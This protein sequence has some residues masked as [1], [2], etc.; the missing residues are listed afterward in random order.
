MLFFA[1]AKNPVEIEE[2]SA[3]KVETGP[4]Q[5]RYLLKLETDA[6]KSKEPADLP[7]TVVHSYPSA[8]FLTSFSP[9]EIVAR[10]CIQELSERSVVPVNYRRSYILTFEKYVFPLIGNM[11][12]NSVLESD[13][14]AVISYENI[15]A[16]IGFQRYRIFLMIASIFRYSMAHNLIL[17]NPCSNI[18]CFYQQP[19][20]PYRE[21][22]QSECNALL[23]AFQAARFK[24][25]IL[26]SF[27]TGIPIPEALMLSR[28]NVDL[29]SGKAVISQRM[30]VNGPHD[31]FPR[32]I[33][34][35]TIPLPEDGISILRDIHLPADEIYFFNSEKDSA[36]TT[37]M[38]MDLQEIRHHSGISDFSYRDL[39]ENFIMR[40]LKADVDIASLENY[41]GYRVGS[42]ITRIYVNTAG[43]L[44][45]SI[46]ASYRKKRR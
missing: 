43:I 14:K 21:F 17:F 2:T 4:K 31:S 29:Y 15:P 19:C 36:N 16:C 13:V 20:K 3:P 35:R 37:S 8:P 6:Q 9:F 18:R 46:W 25:V 24:K 30:V 10:Q 41:F 45:D 7:S 33:K 12:V 11:P 22:S 1:S 26:F 23:D 44:P 5:P 38:N 27:L 34:E 42:I 40:C 39:T 32:P 28:N